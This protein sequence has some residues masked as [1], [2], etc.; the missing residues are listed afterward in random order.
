MFSARCKL[1]GYPNDTFE[2]QNPYHESLVNKTIPVTDGKLSECKMFDVNKTAGNP[3]KS[4]TETECS[5]WVYDKSV[6]TSTVVTDLDLVCS[7]TIYR[8]HTSMMIS[9]GKF[10]GALA[11]SIAG[12]YFGRRSVYTFMMLGLAVS[13][14]GVVFAYNVPLLMACRFVAGASSVG[15][16]ISCSL[17][18]SELLGTS[19]RRWTSVATRISSVLVKLMITL[20]AFFLRD[21]HYF[22]ASLAVPVVFVL[23][24]FFFVPESPRWLVS[25]GRFKEAQKVLDAVAK[26]N[27]KVPTSRFE[28]GAIHT[29]R[30]VL[31]KQETKKTASP[32][33][34]FR[35]PRLTKRYI[36]LYF[37]WILTAMCSFGLALNVSN[38]SGDIFVNFLLLTAADVVAL[39]LFAGLVEHVGRRPLI[40]GVSGAGGLACLATILPVA[41]GG[42]DWILRLLSLGGR[43]YVSTGTPGLHTMSFELFPTVLA[44]FGLGSCNMLSRVGGLASPYVADLSL[45][46]KGAWGPALPQIVFGVSGLVT[47]I[48]VFTLPETKGRLLPETVQDAENFGRI[49]M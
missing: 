5:E 35:V 34:L 38:M 8:S 25:K 19:K 10:V 4:E 39:F 14:V 3:G 32:L 22:Q 6:F 21:W 40:V 33:S 16:S 41:L 1:P 29:I 20:L 23:A 13:S 17:I 24:G 42:S 31:A 36:F 12:D 48:L 26:A 11:S 44:S 27:G 37:A 47:A 9:A 28:Q 30:D 49:L 46:V 7:N 43:V 18:S 2:L 45:Y 15:A